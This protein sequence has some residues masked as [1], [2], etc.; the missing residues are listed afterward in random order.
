MSECPIILVAEDSLVNQKVVSTLLRRWKV[1]ALM[2][3]TGRAAVEA[4]ANADFPV[5]LMDCD[6]PELD[7]LAATRHLRQHLPERRQPWIIAMTAATEDRDQEECARA[8]MDDLLPKPL[9][10]DALL[11][12][13][14]RA[15]LQIGSD[16]A[17]K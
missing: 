3:G 9:R 14:Q 4:F 13:L 11:A 15:G 10:P 2:V 8:G 6:M 1:Q 12:A 5:I 7:G 16:A 17:G